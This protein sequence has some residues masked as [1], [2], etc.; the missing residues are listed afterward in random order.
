MQLNIKDSTSSLTPSLIPT[1]SP[2]YCPSVVEE[3]L[4]KPLVICRVYACIADILGYMAGEVGIRGG[5]AANIAW[6]MAF[7]LLEK[8]DYLAATRA[9]AAERKN[10]TDK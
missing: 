5:P 3:V 6:R 2:N 1:S 7:N 9:L 4:D 10:W 8:E